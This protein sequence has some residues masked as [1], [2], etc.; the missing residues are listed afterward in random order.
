MTLTLDHLMVGGRPQRDP[1]MYQSFPLRQ[2]ERKECAM[3][4]GSAMIERTLD[5]F[6]AE[7]FPI[8]ILRCPS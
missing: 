4:L 6:E 3:T 2:F 7:A 5:Q 1:K 8:T